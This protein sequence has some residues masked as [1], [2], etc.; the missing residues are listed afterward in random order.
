M[1]SAM[2]FSLASKSPVAPALLDRLELGVVGLLELLEATFCAS[3][4]L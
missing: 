3:M 1:S 4:R 2:A